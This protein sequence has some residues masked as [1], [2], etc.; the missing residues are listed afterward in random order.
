M[1][2]ADI[3]IQIT[4]AFQDE[5]DLCL[6]DQAME[7]VTDRLSIPDEMLIGMELVGKVRSSEDIING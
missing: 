7:A 4:V 1:Y 5:G 2:Y 3:N 6:E